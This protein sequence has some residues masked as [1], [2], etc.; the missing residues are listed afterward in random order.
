MYGMLTEEE[1]IDNILVHKDRDYWGC[2]ERE[3]G[4]LGVYVINIIHELCVEY[5]FMKTIL[6][7]LKMYNPYYE[8]TYKM[9][10]YYL[11]ETGVDFV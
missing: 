1:Y 7:Y 3:Q 8:L 2:F 10:E 4:K 11:F 9:N 6:E 5:T